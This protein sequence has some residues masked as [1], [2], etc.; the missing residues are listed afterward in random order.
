MIK[1]GACGTELST[2][3]AVTV[4][5]GPIQRYWTGLIDDKWNEPGNWNPSGAPG[6]LDDAIIPAT[7]SHMPVVRVQGYSCNNILIQ[8]GASCTVNP[9]ITLTINGELTIEGQ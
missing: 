2:P 8:L 9:G 6:A 4:V 1:N 3:A 7:A 5:P